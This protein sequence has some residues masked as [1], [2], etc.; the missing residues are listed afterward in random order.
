M[1]NRFKDFGSERPKELPFASIDAYKLILSTYR[2]VVPVPEL[3]DRLN[4]S[5]DVLGDDFVDAEIA[6][7]NVS[8][9]RRLN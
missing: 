9:A 2:D 4:R 7:L 1:L 3:E 8:D 5:R 6:R